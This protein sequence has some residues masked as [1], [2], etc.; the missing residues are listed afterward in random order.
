MSVVVPRS[1]RPRGSCGHGPCVGDLHARGAALRCLSARGPCAASRDW[2][3]SSSSRRRAVGCPFARTRDWLRGR[4]VAA[5]TAGSP[6]D[7]G[8]RSPRRLGHHDAD[9]IGLAARSLEREGFLDLARGEAPCIGRDRVGRHPNVMIGD[10]LAGGAWCSRSLPHHRASVRRHRR[11]SERLACRWLPRDAHSA[12]R[13]GISAVR[14]RRTGE[15]AGACSWIADG[16]PRRCLSRGPSPCARAGNEAALVDDRPRRRGRT[17]CAPD[18][19]VRSDVRRTTAWL[20][21]RRPPAPIDDGLAGVPRAKDLSASMPTDAR[22][23]AVRGSRPTSSTRIRAVTAPRRLLRLRFVGD[24]R[25]CPTLRPRT[26]PRRCPPTTRRSSRWTC[27][28]F[29]RHWAAQRRARRRSPP[30]R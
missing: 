13:P 15:T 9:A 8:C 5:V 29:A 21:L 12:S 11:E 26:P 24:A 1:A 20:V 30:R 28:A 14:C 16:N 25:H 10:L 23:L 3:S 19:H 6:G 18:A 4:L 17:S 22:A 27:A 7:A 2:W